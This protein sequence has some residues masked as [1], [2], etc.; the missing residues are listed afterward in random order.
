MAKHRKAR[1][2]GFN[3]VALE[4][5]DAAGICFRPVICNMKNGTAARPTRHRRLLW[6]I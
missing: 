5:G 4:V 6:P 1:A 2:V 3:H